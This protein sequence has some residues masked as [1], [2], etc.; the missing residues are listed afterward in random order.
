MS[1]TEQFSAVLPYSG[2]I[3]YHY[4]KSDTGGSGS[5]SYH[6]EIP[7]HIAINVN[8]VPF[9]GSI[10]GCNNSIDM[11]TGSVVAMNSAQC[12]AIAQTAEEVSKSLIDGFFGTINTE[13]SQQIQ[14]LDSAIKAGLGLIREQAAAVSAQKNT[15]ENDY[16][17]ISSRYVT[18]F[19]DL[20]NECYKRIYA[21]DKPS[22]ALSEK[23]RK[24][25]LTETR[26]NSIALNLLAME[27]ESSSK[28]FLLISGMNR[29]TQDVLRTLHD[30]ITQE[31]RFTHLVNSF[32][33]EEQVKDKIVIYLPVLFME[34][35]FLENI[36]TNRETFAPD[37]VHE[38]RQSS[39]AESVTRY[40]A[41]NSGN[42]KSILNNQEKEL[43][44]REFN[45][46]VESHFAAA[47][48]EKDRRVYETLLSLWKTSGK[49][50]INDRSIT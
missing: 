34:S 49:T 26:D 42:V 8:T 47:S 5:V 23:V 43:V 14:A 40:C 33:Y 18:L 27:E 35:D 50:A 29:K 11:L 16:N 41:G 22:F 30:Y 44:S 24:Q 1:Y 45:S 32:L 9:D 31:S 37:F 3:S 39:I 17:R 4:P 46:L 20:D 48:D 36:G 38:E 21:L 19:V 15:M 28:I 12:A 13:L 6:G 25:L 2:S 10:N 7:V